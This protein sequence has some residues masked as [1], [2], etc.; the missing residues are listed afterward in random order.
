MSTKETK[1]PKE[2]KHR[3]EALRLPQRKDSLTQVLT[4]I[5]GKTIPPKAAST[6]SSASTQSAPASPAQGLSK[7]RRHSHG[8][9]VKKK[10][11]TTS[12]TLRRF[13]FTNLTG[14]MEETG[15][16]TKNPKASEGTPGNKNA[17][18]GSSEKVNKT[19][20][21][22][23]QAPSA[24][25]SQEKVPSSPPPMPKSILRVASPDAARP[26][27][28]HIRSYSTSAA[29]PGAD[30]AAL[31]PI[32]LTPLTPTDSS[33]DPLAAESGTLSQ[34]TSPVF[35]PLSPGA[36]VRF[37]KATIHRVD[38][39]PGRRFAPVKRRSKS[40]MTY[41]AP[42][43]PVS[44]VPKFSLQSPTK[45]RRHQENQAAMGRYW[46]RTEE[47]EAQMRAEAERRAAEE[48]ERYRA[49][50]SSPI[51]SAD[52]P[53]PSWAERLAALD[54]LGSLDG[55]P[56]L[57]KTE[58][59]AKSDAEDKLETVEASE[60]DDSDAESDGGASTMMDK[61]EDVEGVEPEGKSEKTEKKKAES[62]VEKQANPAEA[63]AKP[64]GG[65]TVQATPPEPTPP[66][67]GE[68]EKTDPAVGKP[69]GSR[70]PET[71]QAAPVTSPET[72]KSEPTKAETP[73]TPASLMVSTTP[74]T[75]QRPVHDQDTDDHINH[76]D[77][78]QSVGNNSNYSQNLDNYN[79][80]H[81]G[82][83]RDFKPNHQQIIHPITFT[84]HQHISNNSNT[85]TPNPNNRTQNPPLLP[86][87]LAHTA[88]AATHKPPP[89]TPS[90]LAAPTIL[91]RTKTQK[92]HGHVERYRD[93]G[94]RRR[95]DQPFT[96]LWAAGR[97]ASSIIHTSSPRW[98]FFLNKFLRIY[99]F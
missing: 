72:K 13:S 71:A 86:F 19:N 56:L 67:P 16:K 42:L 40:T 89:L 94:E 1:E 18:S 64:D 74:A 51:A 41:I 59:P 28:R 75:Q 98:R 22:K 3:P 38:V 62:D 12:T 78:D 44:N 17:K 80:D 87:P 21:S 49:E 24:D 69:L 88:A 65:S 90:P 33:L 7:P 55:I 27:P 77:R 11:R 73:K 31:S 70:G 84:Q 66:K 23:S 37:A 34:P 79:Q 14:I 5:Q 60:S 96:S 82:L 15:A 93:R 43:D 10:A 52:P 39:G 50:P 4:Y 46:L 32:G 91:A 63:S 68:P 36:T 47:E 61:E 8:P 26:P 99:Y 30:A 83:N 35:R 48:A 25:K 58:V 20:T 92:V 81:H 6:V 29:S 45:L 95:A 2:P 53:K 57:D 76:I 85:T 9:D 97:E 54:K